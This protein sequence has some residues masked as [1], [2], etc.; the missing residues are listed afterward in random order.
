MKLIFELYTTTYLGKENI[1]HYCIEGL[2]KLPTRFKAIKVEDFNFNPTKFLISNPENFINMFPSKFVNEGY[3]KIHFEN[4]D[5]DFFIFW[6]KGDSKYFEKFPGKK[7]SSVTMVIK[8]GLECIKNE[9]E[10]AKLEE[11]WIYLCKK[12]NALYGFCYLDNSVDMRNMAGGHGICLPRLFWK[13]YLNKQYVNEFSITKNSSLEDCLIEF[14]D[15]GSVI[16]TINKSPEKLLSQTDLEKSII[17]QL[18]VDYFWMFGDNT[19]TPRKAYKMPKLDLSEVTLDKPL[20]DDEYYRVPKNINKD[21]LISLISQKSE[22]PLDEATKVL[23]S[24]LEIIEEYLIIHSRI[25]IEGIGIFKL[26]TVPERKGIHPITQKEVIIPSS[27]S[28]H[29]RPDRDMVVFERS[30]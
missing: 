12:L 25:S 9:N 22:L 16:L 30:N 3:A 26:L 19:V 15:N 24:I 10:F 14:Q 4:N 6:N 18:G 28:I 11:I 5:F 7:F 20:F 27:K 21:E 29:F 8:D 17:Q 2:N 23:A 13:T 1:A